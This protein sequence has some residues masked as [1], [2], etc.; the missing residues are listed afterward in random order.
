MNC[1]NFLEALESTDSHQREA[2]R[3]HAEQCPACA[4]LGEVHA[5]L[6]RELSQ[7]QPLPPALRAVWESASSLT[8]RASEGVTPGARHW[9]LQLIALAAALLLLIT[10]SFLIWQSGKQ[11]GINPDI[12]TEDVPKDNLVQPQPAVLAKSIDA[13]EELAELLAQVNA[14]EKELKTT[15]TQADLLDARHQTSALLATYSQW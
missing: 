14:L 8:R 9:P 5:R 13:S 1:E 4:A 6:Q 3:R 15:S 12:V 11:P 2:A 7:V 10:I